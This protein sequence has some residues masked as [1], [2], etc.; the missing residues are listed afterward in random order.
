VA[1]TRIPTYPADVVYETALNSGPLQ[2]SPPPWWTNITPRVLGRWSTARGA[3]YMLARTTAGTWQPV[4][5]NRDGGLDPGNPAGPYYPNLAPY[6]GLRIRMPFGVNRLTA[7]QATAGEQAGYLGAIPPQLG[8]VND[9]LYPISIVASGSAYQ[10]SQVYQ[11]T[12][13]SGATAGAT[14]LLVTGV[15]VLPRAPYNFQAQCRITSGNS[16]STQASILWLDANGNLLS[17]STVLGTASTLTSGSSTWVTL[18]A[19][20]AAAPSGAYSAQLKVQI[21][22]GTLTG[23]TTW[24]L[25]GLQFEQSPVAS[26][27][28]MPGTLGANLLPQMIAGGLTLLDPTKD[29]ASNYFQTS[30]PVASTFARVTGLTAAPTGHT[31]AVAWTVTAAGAGGASTLNDSV[32]NAVA[33]GPAQDCV[34]VVAGQTYTAS[35]YLSRASSADATVQVTQQ[36]TWYDATGAAIFVASSS[37]AIVPVGSWV[38]A[39]ATLTAP[40]GAVWG[41][42]SIAV[43]NVPSATNTIYSTALQFEQAGSASAWVDPGPTFYPWWGA[44]EQFPQRWR[45]SGT[46]GES[47]AV[48][49]DALAGLAQYTVGQPLVEE[50]LALSP[51][52]LYTLS[53]PAGSSSC[54]DQTGNRGP[55]PVENSPAGAGS[56]TFGNSVTATSS[57]GLMQGSA[58]PVATFNNNPAGAGQAVQEAETYVSI[59][60]T[61]VTPGPPQTGG[62]TRII[63]FR[64]STA[65]ATGSAYAL[66]EA[67]PQTALLPTNGSLVSFAVFAGGD[68]AMSVQGASGT[69][70][71]YIGA[72]NICDGNWHQM[73]ATCDTSGNVK[74]Y[75]DGAAVTPNQNSGNTVVTL[76]ISAITSDVLGASIQLG[77]QYFRSGLVGDL[78]CAAEFPAVLTAAQIT[79]LYNSFRSASA[80]EGSGARAAR[81]ATWVGYAGPTAFD[82]GS[83]QSMG[84]ATD[85]AG[86]SALNAFNAIITTEN[87]DGYV[88]GG[89]VLTFKGRS[90]RYNSSPLFIFGEGAPV[91]HVGEWPTEDVQFSTDPMNTYN[92]IPTQ[93]YSSGQVA[94]AQDAASQQA[95]WPRTAPTIVVN[96]TSFAEVQA[97]GQYQL[98]R[99]KTPRLRLSSMTL[100]P[101]AVPG[102]WRVCAQL[103]KGVRIRVMKRP[104]WRATSAPIQFDG[105][106][107]R[108]EWNLDA[109]SGDATVR[110]EASPAD[111][112]TYWV[113][114]ALHTTLHSQAA[115]GQNQATINALPDS[116]VNALASSLPQGYQLTFD[117]GTPIA[118]TL[119]L[120]PTGIPSTTPGYSTATLTF[121]ANFAFTHAANAIVCEALPSGYTDPT[122]WD[123]SSVLGAASTTVLSGGGSGTNTVTVGPLAD[124]ATNP[125]GSDWNVGDLLWISPGT[126]SFEGYNLLHPNVSTAGEGALPL[127]AGSTVAGTGAFYGTPTITASASAW[128]GSQ[129]WQTAVG[130]SASTGHTLFFLLKI[131]I[132]ASLP[133]TWSTY[134]RSATTGANPSVE[135]LVTWF[136]AN[137]NSLGSIT[138]SQ[139]ALTGSPTAAWTRLTLS[140]TAPAGAVWAEVAIFLEGTTP[141]SAWNFQYDGLQFEQAGSAST[142]CTTP[143]VKSVATSVAGYSSVQITLNSNLINSHSR[144]D[145]VCDPLPAGL[146]SPTQIAATTRIAY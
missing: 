1:T 8:V 95:Y 12:A 26:P 141:T 48:G 62:W 123:A 90:A 78:A 91:G 43:S 3:S 114:G 16:V 58:G 28:Q 47:D 79:N 137:S 63:H 112:A 93:Q 59:H 5:D 125:L 13:P 44:W 124:S 27:W 133:Y 25:D 60:K 33:A 17:T 50:L 117:P 134:V 97:A 4:L 40:A 64:S 100:H 37:N 87:G 6:K 30:G 145:T 56:L 143:Q 15:P 146:T 131:P 71:E 65:P 88:S 42:G 98:G 135:L 89:G 14:V 67:L 38:R 23:S 53:D 21:A 84:P 54:T 86:Q 51:N 126:P 132:T 31:T 75:V 11:V 107:E 144:G 73:A 49:T 7:D 106:V 57:S 136:D 119:T 77:A 85:L 46:W 55:A 83:T 102:L 69:F 10:G 68:P 36:I 115:S 74:M 113:L 130:A 142:Y 76:P 72:P 66:W 108:V 70:V 81:L 94:I 32:N 121:T 105:F 127:A 82:A 45:L 99:L 41:R 80:G 34:Q 138:S 101:A 116:A 20:A 118:E 35:R 122:T 128:Q 139:T 110:V 22:S 109:V 18:S 19:S 24:Q 120:S 39:T 111:P 52:F 2:S 103:E 140:G 96:S 92:I 104:P 129:V 29:S 61:T 9:A